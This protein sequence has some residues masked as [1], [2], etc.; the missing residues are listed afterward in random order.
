M[1]V[2]R[3][4]SIPH[5]KSSPRFQWVLGSLEVSTR[6]AQGCRESGDSKRTTVGRAGR[7]VRGTSWS[8]RRCSMR[9]RPIAAMGRHPRD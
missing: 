8:V 2:W 1:A 3:R 5:C 4:K 6:R 7:A 9:C